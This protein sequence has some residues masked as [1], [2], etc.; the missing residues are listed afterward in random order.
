[1]RILI[2]KISSMG[3]II[4]NLPILRDIKIR[5]PEAEIDWV[6]EE[7][8]SDILKFHP[9]IHTIIPV[10]FRRWRHEIFSQTTYQE[11][12][13]FR[14]LLQAK[15]YD[16]IIDTQTLLKSALISYMA[17][18]KRYGQAFRTSREPLASFFYQQRFRVSRKQHA[19]DQNRQLTALSLNYPIPMNEPDYGL[20]RASIASQSSVTLPEN[21]VMFFHATSRESKLWPSAHWVSLGIAL[22]KKGAVICLPWSN[23]KEKTR[24]QIIANH[25]PNAL[26]LPQLDLAALSMIIAQAQCAFGVDTGLIHLSV[27][28]EIPSIAIYTDTHPELNGTYPSA[29]TIAINLGGKDVIPS[30]E[31][32][33]HAFERLGVFA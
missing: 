30:V 6:V 19:V 8:F 16:L 23:E 7:N 13:Q 27:A 11:F 29:N 2:V 3:D 14:Q 20:S 4:H 15:R 5:Y 17:K 28:M 1:L 21:A 31:E 18:G 10:A 33:L 9:D 32:A 22:A 24:A 25:I 12:K 26:L